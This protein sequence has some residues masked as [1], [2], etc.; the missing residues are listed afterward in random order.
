MGYGLHRDLAAMGI[1]NVVVRPQDWDELHKGVK[2]DKTDALALVQRL[3][4][5]VQ[6]NLK[7][8]AVV[9]VPTPTQEL[10]RTQS[11]LR[12]QLL[13]HRQR[14][15]AQGRSLLL[16]SGIRVK[17]RWWQDKPWALL[18]GRVS[19]A[20]LELLQVIRALLLAVQEQLNAAT[21]R[22][23]SAASPQVCG[24]GALTSQVLEREILDWHRFANR[25]QVASMTGMCPG[26][27]S[28]GPR[29]RNGPITKHGNRRVRTALIELAWRCVRF[30]PDYPPIKRW[31]PALLNPKATGA[32]KKK[33]IVAVGR[34]LA[35]DLWRLNTGRTTAQ[36]L[37]LK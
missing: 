32:V 1:H 10:A 5:Y 36:K 18:E 24:V 26:V 35:I 28:S 25:R 34:K 16:F 27:R 22:L 30:Q 7:E 37:S 29:T 9:R 21:T 17:G 8:L 20:L 4:R 19:P 2:T 11:R 12:E 15:E 33:A 3:G 23:Q 13:S 14:F 31:R 6:G